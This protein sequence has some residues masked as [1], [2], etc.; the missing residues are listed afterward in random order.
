MKGKE[1]MGNSE[2][3][4]TTAEAVKKLSETFGSIDTKYMLK[5]LA[6][7]E[8]IS[9]LEKALGDLGAFSK[10]SKYLA[11]AA[12]FLEV[13]KAIAGVKSPEQQIMG[14]I[15][16]LSEQVAGFQDNVTVR[17]KRLGDKVTKLAEVA[18][19]FNH[20]NNIKTYQEQ[21]NEYWKLVT[22]GVQGYDL[23]DAEYNIE[24]FEQED[25]QKAVTAIHDIAKK[26]LEAVYVEKYGG[27][28]VRRLGLELQGRAAAAPGIEAAYWRVMYRDKSS[29]ERAGLLESARKRMDKFY[30]EK[31]DH[32]TSIVSSATKKCLNFENLKSNYPKRVKAFIDRQ[33]ATDSSDRKAYL[34]NIADGLLEE[35]MKGYSLLDWSVA[36]YNGNR[37]W[38]Y[39]GYPSWGKH[40]SPADR[41]LF[42]STPLT[43]WNGKMTSKISK[44]GTINIVV[45]VKDRSNADLKLPDGIQ[46]KLQRVVNSMEDEPDKYEPYFFGGGGVVTRPGKKVDV[47]P[48]LKKLKSENSMALLVRGTEFPTWS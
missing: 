5:T 41:R 2:L 12:M 24:G 48:Y 35:L 33:D 28:E 17:F 3:S 26:A 36:V 27:D 18:K 6:A 11:A 38:M 25:L 14:M 10:A 7:P 13:G 8:S 23:E 20:L 9:S 19:L 43:G 32:I 42:W 46:G 31:L 16:T 22:D 21:T 4:A 34:S 30:T 44:K 39:H 29:V 37:G 45:S 40:D 1:A 47:R 15:D